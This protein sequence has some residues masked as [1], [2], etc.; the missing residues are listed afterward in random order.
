VLSTQFN[1]IPGYRIRRLYIEEI[2]D[3]RCGAHAPQATH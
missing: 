3:C 1:P 2:F